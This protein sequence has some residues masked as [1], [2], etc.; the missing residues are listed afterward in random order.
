MKPQGPLGAQPQLFPA[1]YRASRSSQA[2]SGG[3]KCPMAVYERGGNSERPSQAGPT[4]DTKLLKS[5]KELWLPPNSHC[6][7]PDRTRG[8][9]VLV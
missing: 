7:S 6:T 8:L 5:S 2:Q 1:A 4:A 3:S 9:L